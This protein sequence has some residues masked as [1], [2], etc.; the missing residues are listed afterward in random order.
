LLDRLVPIDQLKVIQREP[1]PV[2]AMENIFEVNK[3][4]NHR[5]RDGAKEYLVDWRGYDERTWEPETNIL[6]E[7]PVIEYWKRLRM[8]SENVSGKELTRKRKENIR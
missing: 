1:G 4:V 2:D 5:I 3:I 6:D 8:K 7:R